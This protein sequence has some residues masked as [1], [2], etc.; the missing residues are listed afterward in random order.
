[1]QLSGLEREVVGLI[2]YHGWKQKEVAELLSVSER[3]ARRY[4][5]Q[6]CC[7][8]KELVQGDLPSL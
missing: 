2:F 7:R 3:Q 5:L 6:A 4:W 1:M 8:L